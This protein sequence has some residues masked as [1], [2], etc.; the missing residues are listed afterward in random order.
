MAIILTDAFLQATQTDEQDLKLEIA[1]WLYEKRKI[2]LGKAS[3]M[4]EL[5]KFKFQHI[6]AD[7]RIA[8]NYNYEAFVEDLESS[9]NF[10]KTK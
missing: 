3:E 6:L 2:S 10:Q 4:A 9:K 8:V 7:R 5:P 1:I